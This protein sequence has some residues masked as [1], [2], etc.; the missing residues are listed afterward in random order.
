MRDEWGVKM[1]ISK[2]KGIMAEHG[3]SG[4]KLAIEADMNIETMRRKLRT[5]KFG[6]DE[7][8]KIA[9]ILSI[10]NP[11]EIFFDKTDT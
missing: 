8:A 3:Y 1:N 9:R 4:T 2:L 6:I 7:A 5:G 11:G 10:D